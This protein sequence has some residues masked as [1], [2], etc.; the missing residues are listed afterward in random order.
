MK[1][2]ITNNLKLYLDSKYK[3]ESLLYRYSINEKLYY[4]GKRWY[5]EKEVNKYYPIY[6]Y[7]KYKLDNPNYNNLL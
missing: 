4:D 3:R 1:K 7:S 5:T 2:N 6:H